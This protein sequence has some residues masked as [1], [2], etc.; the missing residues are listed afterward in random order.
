MYRVAL[1]HPELVSVLFS[2]CT[3]YWEPTKEN[4]ITLDQLVKHLLPNFGYQ[5]HLSSG[6][7]EKVIESKDKIKE[8]LNGMY[9]GKG[10][11]GKVGFS[12]YTGI[13]FDNL[14]KLAANPLLSAKV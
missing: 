11:D 13:L 6:E 7:V 9:G 10:P 14:P 8:F 5:L 12:P 1:W 3:P 2:V 4:F